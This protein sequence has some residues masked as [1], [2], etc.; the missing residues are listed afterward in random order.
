VACAS[1]RVTMM[2]I[3]TNRANDSAQEVTT[4]GLF[5]TDGEG[6]PDASDCAP[7]DPDAWSVPGEVTDLV[8]PGGPDPA[9]MQWQ[10]P[11]IPGGSM[12]R[13]DLLRGTAKDDFSA[14]TCVA[15]DPTST[16]APDTALPSVV[17]FHLVRAETVCGGN[18]GT[19][20][21]GT[22]RT[23]QPCP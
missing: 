18:P 11:A 8:I 7:G 2:P 10:A 21:D 6:V 20:S 12:V 16:S 23:A 17:L 14:A 19:R 9:L 3:D 1:D 13:Y 22:L 15:S 5:D 4:V